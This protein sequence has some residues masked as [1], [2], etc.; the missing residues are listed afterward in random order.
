MGLQLGML[1][2]SV[3]RTGELP[4]EDRADPKVVNLRL[5]SF[6]GMKKYEDAAISWLKE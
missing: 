2:I 5:G 4:P 6:I 1:A 3:G